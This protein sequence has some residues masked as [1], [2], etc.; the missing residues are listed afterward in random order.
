MIGHVE[1]HHGHGMHE[2]GNRWGAPFGRNDTDGDGVLSTDEMQ[3]MVDKINERRML[4][5]EDFS[6]RL[7]SDGDGGVTAE[8]FQAIHGMRHGA[9]WRRDGYSHPERSRHSDRAFGRIDTD[10]SGDLSFDEVET[11]LARFDGVTDEPVDAEEIFAMANTDKT[12]ESEDGTDAVL[13]REEAKGLRE[14]LG[15]PWQLRR[16]GPAYLQGTTET[17]DAEDETEGNAEGVIEAGVAEAEG[18]ADTAVAGE[19]TADMTAEIPA[20]DASTVTNA[21]PVSQTEA[22]ALM[23]EL[24]ETPDGATTEGRAAEVSTSSV[25]EGAAQVTTTAAAAAVPGESSAASPEDGMLSVEI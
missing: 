15:N 16:F 9:W 8:E 24:V 25:V 4:T 5:L 11:F 20:L 7:D 19:G 17:E 14:I 23:S 12:G 6:A 13:S 1:R 10:K 21:T 18:T 22:G 3:V 2:L